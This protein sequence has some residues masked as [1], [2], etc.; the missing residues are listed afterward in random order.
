MNAIPQNVEIVASGFSGQIG[1]KEFICLE[2]RVMSFMQT[3]KILSLEALPTALDVVGHFIAETN[4]NRIYCS[5]DGG[6]ERL[7]R[8]CRLFKGQNI[9]PDESENKVK[10]DFA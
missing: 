5:L 8:I 7:A 10:S 2:A 6:L 3:N 9:T 4:G 1:H